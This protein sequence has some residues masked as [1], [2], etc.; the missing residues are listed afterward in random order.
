MASFTQKERE[1]LLVL[2][3]DYTALYN[4]HS[5]SKLLKIS[6]VG[7]QKMLKRLKEEHLAVAK[8]IGKS[9]IYKPNLEDDFTRSTISFLLADEASGYKR[10]KE[11]FKELFKPDRIVILFG[12]IIM[13]A[14]E[15]RD[16]DVMVIIKQGEYKQIKDAID[17]RQR[18]LPRPIHSIELT[19]ED[20]LK[21]LQKKGEEFVDIIRTGIILYGH[22]DYVEAIRNVS[23]F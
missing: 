20:L 15:A 18:M 1:A 9:I 12:S 10:W 3:K 13:N 16:I 8:T 22:Q 6:H 2:F 4:A 17:K 19:K 14:K 5:L 11:E 7:T 21:N 23:G